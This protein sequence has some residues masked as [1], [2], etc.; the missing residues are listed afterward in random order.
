MNHHQKN[1]QNLSQAMDTL[2]F[3]WS[4][5]CEFEAKTLKLVFHRP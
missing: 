5:M 3:P 4:V 1:D 2:V